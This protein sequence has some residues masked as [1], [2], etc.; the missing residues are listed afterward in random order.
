MIH[1]ESNGALE[2]M[3]D[4]GGVE[5]LTCCVANVWG[6]VDLDFTRAGHAIGCRFGCFA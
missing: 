6:N 5:L 1:F 3:D 2:S 4:T